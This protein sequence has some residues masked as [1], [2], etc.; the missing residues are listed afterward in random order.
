MD[1]QT[2]VQLIPQM[3]FPVPVP[4]LV[5]EPFRGSNFACPS[6]PPVPVR[7]P[8]RHQFGRPRQPTPVRSLPVPVRVSEVCPSQF[9]IRGETLPVLVRDYWGAVP[10]WD[11]ACPS[12]PP[13]SRPVWPAHQPTPVQSLPVPVRVDS[14]RQSGTYRPNHACPSSSPG[15]KLCLSQFGICLSLGFPSPGAVPG[16]IPGWK[17]ACPSSGVP[18]RQSGTYRPNHACPSSSLRSLPVPVRVPVRVCP[19]STGVS[20]RGPVRVKLCLSQFGI[21]LGSRSGVE[22]C[23]S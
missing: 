9:G 17:F 22:V 23:L 4:V 15:V 21:R 3:S 2:G 11:F 6:S 13:S 1:T 12:S 7:L 16:A 5:R 19:S 20:V 14:L 10:G 8:I 18:L